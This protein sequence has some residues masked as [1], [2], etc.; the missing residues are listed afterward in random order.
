MTD[1]LNIFILCNAIGQTATTIAK[2]TMY[3]FPDTDYDIKTYSFMDSKEK[4]SEVIKQMEDVKGPKIIFHTFANPDFEMHLSKEIEGTSI[5]AHD[6]LRPAIDKVSTLIHQQPSN[7]NEQIAQL[8]KRYFHRIDALEYSVAHDDGKNPSGYPAADILILGV[9]RTSK[10]PLSIYLANQNY[11]VANLPIMPEAELP[12]E[13][14]SVDKGKIVGLTNDIDILMSIRQE[15]LAS[16]GMDM[17]SPY[18]SRERIEKELQYA[19]DLYDQIGCQVINVANRSIE[20]T[21]S[22]ILSN[23]ESKNNNDMFTTL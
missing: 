10:T 11:R 14:W 15:R 17:H 18:S 5:I 3:Q 22:I 2:A 23:L 19:R 4:I 20:E 8:N 12:K 9:S 7:A 21:A 1:Y 13:L 16:Y 6:I